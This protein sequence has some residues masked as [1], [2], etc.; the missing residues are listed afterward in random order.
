[1]V[2]SQ[3]P[4]PPPRKAKS[5]ESC[6]TH[7]VPVRDAPPL[8]ARP[9]SKDATTIETTSTTTTTTTA[10]KSLSSFIDGN[11]AWKQAPYEDFNLTI[12]GIVRDA[13]FISNDAIVVAEMMNVRAYSL[14]NGKPIWSSADYLKPSCVH[15]VDSVAIVGCSDGHVIFMDTL[16]GTILCEHLNAHG[17]SSV[18][19]AMHD[20]GLIYT[21]D[22]SGTIN[23]WD[24]S[25]R[26]QSAWQMNRTTSLIAVNKKSAMSALGKT[27]VMFD[28]SSGNVL[29]LLVPVG[30]SN[31]TSI[32]SACGEEEF[33]SGHE[34]GKLVLWKGSSCEVLA[35]ASCFKVQALAFVDG[36]LWAGDSLGNI[37]V[38]D[39]RQKQVLLEW[40]HHNSCIVRL[41]QNEKNVLSVDTEG[42]FGLWDRSL[43]GYRLHKEILGLGESYSKSRQLSV[44]VG[45]W[46][47]GA[48]RPPVDLDFYTKW[49]QAGDPDL[50]AISLQE[51]VE[52]T[53]TTN[54]GED[55]KQWTDRLKAFLSPNYSLKE[56]QV[57]LGLMLLVF[58]KK[59]VCVGLVET[60]H[61]KTGMGGHYGNKGGIGIRILVEDTSFCFV[62]CHLAA[63]QGEVAARNADLANIMS[64]L[65]FER[66]CGRKDALSCGGDGSL[67]FDHQN[68]ILC[69]DL[70]YRIDNMPADAR[71]EFTELLKQDQLHSQRILNPSGALRRFEEV[72]RVGFAPTYKYERHTDQYNSERTP[73]W[74]D[75]ILIR[76]QEA[77][78]LKEYDTIGDMKIS[79]H[80]PVY[81]HF[82]LPVRSIDKRKRALIGAECLLNLLQ[83]QQRQHQ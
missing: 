17:R 43:L 40:K 29:E 26:R 53:T 23:A 1:M 77:Y 46:N 61:V 19:N 27:L 21:V 8:P 56:S 15:C 42:A 41:K 64:G 2:I 10:P 48:C 79:D 58:V 38:I 20:E 12:R 6:S 51:I 80:R 39:L 52:L 13:D 78:D 68:V 25:G 66:L 3:P 83:K 59:G 62:G 63:G 7:L 36:L 4:I 14:N 37:R 49:L 9:A 31:V 70:N 57:M 44:R 24:K 33:V 76:T 71:G 45:S 35:L 28:F 65:K 54:S 55:A 67:V 60:S 82:V 81:A 32:A 16:T 11:W 5:M 47:V 75:R 72:G 18:I 22:D 30:V 74:C 69:G 34:D 73:A 50:I